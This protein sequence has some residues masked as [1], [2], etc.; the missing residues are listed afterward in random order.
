MLQPLFHLNRL[1]HKSLLLNPNSKLCTN[2]RR[3]HMEGQLYYLLKNFFL[4]F[5]RSLNV[6]RRFY[7][8]VHI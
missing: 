6:F 8:A 4:S 1:D 5:L 7:G 3:I 2:L